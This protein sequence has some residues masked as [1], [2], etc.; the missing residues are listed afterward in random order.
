[1]FLVLFVTVLLSSYTYMD[2]LFKIPANVEVPSPFYSNLYVPFLLYRA[3]E[4]Q[5]QKTLKRVKMGICKRTAMK[6]T[7]FFRKK[8]K[9][10]KKKD[11]TLL[12]D[13]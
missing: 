9:N 13:T 7:I 8:V 4:K 12:S 3:D 10:K 1:M 11:V 5:K 6:H 2:R